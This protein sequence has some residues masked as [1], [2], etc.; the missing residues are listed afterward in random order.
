MS[1]PADGWFRF[2]AYAAFDEIDGL[3]VLHHS[4]YLT[5]LE[6]ASL[7]WFGEMLGMQEFDPIHFPDLYQ[8]VHR[9]E[10]DYLEPIRGPQS[11]EI[12]IAVERVRAGALVTRFQF[13]SPKDGRIFCK[14]LRTVVRMSQSNHQP[15]LWSESF[16]QTLLD[17]KA[18]HL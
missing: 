3:G 16:Y 4:R 5:H 9:V 18:A 12:R 17:W 14:G 10:I 8:L 7:A 15:A 2:A 6:R 13:H 1:V 11:L